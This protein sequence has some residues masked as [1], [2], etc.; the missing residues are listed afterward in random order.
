MSGAETTVPE[1]QVGPVPAENPEPATTDSTPV[2]ELP[3]G[4]PEKAEA[5]TPKEA[6]PAALSELPVENPATPVESPS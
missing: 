4:E 3:G 6:P 1:S 2:E 5:E